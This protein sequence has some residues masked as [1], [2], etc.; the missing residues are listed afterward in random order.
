MDKLLMSKKFHSLRPLEN[1]KIPAEG[2]IRKVS[3]SLFAHGEDVVSCS[4][5]S[6]RK[7][8]RIGNIP[9]LHHGDIVKIFADGSI[10][11]L[12]DVTSPHNCLFVTSVCNFRCVMCPQPPQAEREKHHQTNLRI[13]EL[14]E[15]DTVE[16]MA[17]TGGEPT[18]F[19]DRLVEYFDIICRKFPTAKVDVLTN[20]SPLSDFDT[21]KRLALA[22]PLN[23]CYCVSVH[24]DTAALAESVMHC[25]GGWDKAMRGLNN[26]AKLHQQIEIRYVLTQKSVP[27]LRDIALFF[28]RNFPF[29]SHVALMGQEIIGLAE[30]NYTVT[31]VEPMSY[32]QDLAA[33]AEYL[34]LMNMNVSIYNIPLCLLPASCHKMAVRSISDWKQN[35]RPECHGCK[36][37]DE[38]CGFFTTSRDYVPQGINPF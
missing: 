29:V 23:T 1:K 10:L 34:D 12:W 31:W 37:L 14:L 16:V 24:G 13:L 27:Y 33:A 3:R 36:K 5:V 19:P 25:P 30:E 9:E 38:C 6:L 8:L 28:Y 21:A 18:L 32:M 26:L 4:D 20:G 15:P 7:C 11:R 2:T 17:I 22:A 35:Y